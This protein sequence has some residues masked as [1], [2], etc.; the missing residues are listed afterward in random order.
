MI[1]TPAPGPGIPPQGEETWWAWEQDSASLRRWGKGKGLTQSYLTADW[2]TH[3]ICPAGCWPSLEPRQVWQK[4]PWSCKRGYGC[5]ATWR[6]TLGRAGGKITEGQL[7]VAIREVLVVLGVPLCALAVFMDTLL[8]RGPGVAA[9]N[10]WTD[11]RQARA[12]PGCETFF[13]ELHELL[14]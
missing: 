2:F 6:V 1:L 14:Q 7:R 13:R 4:C 8:C 5:K 9:L 12:S 3:L 10:K 11:P